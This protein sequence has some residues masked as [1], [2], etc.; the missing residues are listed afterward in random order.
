MICVVNDDGENWS[1]NSKPK[2]FRIAPYRAD[3]EE[4]RSQRIIGRDSSVLLKNDIKV[5]LDPALTLFTVC[6]HFT[7]R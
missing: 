2:S 4:Q 3:H 5:P 6:L 1:W 7:V